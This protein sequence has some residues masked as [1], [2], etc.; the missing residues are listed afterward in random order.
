MDDR[1]TAVGY[2]RQSL[3]RPDG[4]A[5]SVRAQLAACRAE[6]TRRDFR[7]EGAYVDEAASA[8]R[9]GFARP[10]F[11]RM[12]TD[13]RHGNVDVVVVNYL[14]RLSRQDVGAV[15][16]GPL[17]GPARSRFLGGWS[18]AVRIRGDRGAQGR[19]HDSAVGRG[20]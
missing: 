12:L 19:S 3:G 20:A 2:A 8:Y 4:S 16:C 11:E 6:A 1:K 14:S 13:V 5:G 18:A 9:S 10:E 7:Y 17:R 15:R